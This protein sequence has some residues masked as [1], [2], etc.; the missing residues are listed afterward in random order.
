[1][2][3]KVSLVKKLQCLILHNCNWF[4]ST[5]HQYNIP[6]QATLQKARLFSRWD[7]DLFWCRSF[8]RFERRF[9]WP[10]AHNGEWSAS[11]HV[12]VFM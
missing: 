5:W 9:S 8:P 1:V 2:K 10:T 4:T 6:D 11:C 7:Y 3:V 12:I